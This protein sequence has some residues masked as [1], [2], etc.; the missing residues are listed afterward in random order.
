MFKINISFK[1]IL[2]FVI[3]L[4]ASIIR[5]LNALVLGNIMEQKSLS[6]NVLLLIFIYAAVEIIIVILLFIY[7]LLLNKVKFEK[8]LKLKNKY[9]Q[10]ET[11][12]TLNIGVIDNLYNTNLEEIDFYINNRIARIYNI[13]YCLTIAICGIFALFW[14]SFEVALIFI[15]SLLLSIFIL[16]KSEHII[17]NFSKDL[18]ANTHKFTEFQNEVFEGHKVIASYQPINYIFKRIR[19]SINLYETSRLLLK[20]KQQL[21]GDLSY[22]PTLCF[23]YLILAFIIIYFPFTKA[24]AIII[25][26]IS[27][28]GWISSSVECLYYDLV[29]IKTTKSLVSKYNSNIKEDN[30]IDLLEIN[31]ISL[32]DYLSFNGK[33]LNY[34]FELG[35]KYFIRGKTGCGKSTLLKQIV[36]EISVVEQ[37]IMINDVDINKISVFDLYKYIAYISQ[38]SYIFNDSLLFN[39][40]LSSSEIDDYEYLYFLLKEFNLNLCKWDLDSLSTFMISENGANLSGGQKQKIVLIRSLYQRKKILFI[41]E[42]TRFLDKESR[43]IIYDYLLGLNDIMVIIIDHDFD[44]FNDKIH[45]LSLD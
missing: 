31:S 14:L 9:L 4:I 1:D 28:E 33:K 27:L 45:I 19:Q 7:S 26:Y 38:D 29:A 30:F 41:D 13:I 40:C 32:K 18:L 2:I 23:Y 43:R 10:K 21:I 34:S 16:T 5:S 22:L 3:L 35:N 12:T 24:L 17:N 39:L 6:N 25:T 37:Q 20:N 44:F 8:R 15:G 36:K 11:K 42:G